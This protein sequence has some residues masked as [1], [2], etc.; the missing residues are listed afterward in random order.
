MHRLL[1]VLLLCASFLAALGGCTALPEAAPAGATFIVVRHAEK[2]NDG[3][4]DPPLSAA[5]E[6]RAE[7][8]AAALRD[9]PLRAAFATAYRRTQGTAAPAA[10]AHALDV[11]TYD[12]ATP[13]DALAA[14]LRAEHRSGTVLVVGHSNTAPEIAAALCGCA[15]APMGDDEYGRRLVIRVDSRGQASLLVDRY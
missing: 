14:R 11:T 15:V 6:A 1:P 5:G 9:A 13:A 4:R 3:T 8:L 2:A 10:R 7:S 12:A